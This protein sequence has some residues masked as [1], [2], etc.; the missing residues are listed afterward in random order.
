MTG[1]VTPWLQPGYA[2]RRGIPVGGLR[3]ITISNALP[4][5]L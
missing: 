5:Q 3:P 1:L 2:M 4:C